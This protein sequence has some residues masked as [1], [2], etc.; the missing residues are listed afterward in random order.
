MR[1]RRSGGDIIVL[2]VKTVLLVEKTSTIPKF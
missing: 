1:K 2:R